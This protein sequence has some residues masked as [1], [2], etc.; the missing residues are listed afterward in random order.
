[1]VCALWLVRLFHNDLRLVAAGYYAG[2][3][4]VGRR[5]LSY[6]NAL[7]SR[8]NP[9]SKMFLNGLAMTNS[10]S[11]AG[12]VHGGQHKVHRQPVHEPGANILVLRRAVSDR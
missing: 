7:G 10:A 4:I 11:V 9:T 12:L 1:V 6:H 5:G 3:D 2:E 8:R